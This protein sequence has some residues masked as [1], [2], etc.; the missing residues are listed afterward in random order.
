MHMLGKQIINLLLTM[1]RT[2]NCDQYCS[3]NQK[4]RRIAIEC[5]ARGL[6]SLGLDPMAQRSFPESDND[7]VY[8]NELSTG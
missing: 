6:S 5:L 7:R 8:H 3:Y 2:S 1:P 4:Y